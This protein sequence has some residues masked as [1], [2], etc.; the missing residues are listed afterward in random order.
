VE[1]KSHQLE[2]LR[3]SAEPIETAAFHFEDDLLP[4]LPVSSLEEMDMLNECLKLGENKAKLVSSKSHELPLM[5]N[6]GLGKILH[7][8]TKYK[9]V[10][11]FCIF[12]T[13]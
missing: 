4:K 9:I 7:Q 12:N 1:I 2:I 5:F 13:L 11:S 10:I 3:R 8:N 6:S